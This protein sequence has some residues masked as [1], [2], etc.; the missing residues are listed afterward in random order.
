MIVVVAGYYFN[1]FSGFLTINYI[2]YIIYA[3]F[4][5][6][7]IYALQFFVFES[8][9]ICSKET[10]KGHLEWKFPGGTID[11]HSI[12][13]KIAYFGFMLLPWLFLKNKTKGRLILLLL[14]LPL[15]YF[16]FNFQ[17]WESLW[18]LFSV[19]MPAIWLVIH[20]NI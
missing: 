18:C 13:I 12:I 10:K 19:S 20:K 1:T 14:L 6:W 11:E 3:I 7:I 15:L 9:N 16:R 4:T 17:E 8:K 5:V 2:K